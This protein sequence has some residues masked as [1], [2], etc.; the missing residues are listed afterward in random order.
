[1]LLPSLQLIFDHKMKLR[2]DGSKIQ[3]QISE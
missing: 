3:F 1:M 2:I